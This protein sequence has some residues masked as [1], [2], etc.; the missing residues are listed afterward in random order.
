MVKIP[1]DVKQK[2]EE[3]GVKM[4]GEG[5]G[6]VPSHGF[7][8]GSFPKNKACLGVMIGKTV[9]NE[10]GVEK[11]TG[12][13][14]EGVAILDVFENSGAADAGLLK[15]DIITAINGEDVT[16]IHEV[17]DVLKPYEGG[18][19]VSIEYL[20]DKQPEQTTATLKAC[21][22]KFNFKK[23]ERHSDVDVDVDEDFEWVFEKEANADAEVHKK[24]TIVIKKRNSNEAE[25]EAFENEVDDNETAATDPVSHT[26]T[27]NEEVSQTLELQEVS[28][29]P[30]PTA[31]NLTVEFKSDAVPTTVK[32]MDITGK[33]VY[34]EEI[35][36]FD[37]T[38]KKEINLS[39]APKGALM[40]TVIQNDKV[41]AD[42]VMVQ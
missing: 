2:M 41:Y 39:D 22:N 28:M 42:K 36:D 29:Y 17:L 6:H 11:V 19:T 15:D 34:S 12:E 33:V 27:S 30:N 20:R 37:G 8:K 38:Y 23:I 7:I 16:T 3:H 18:A 9:E 31:S 5:F 14:E 24:R 32:I 21:E 40:M 10:N 25:I 4:N 35:L 1:D 26:T 13:S